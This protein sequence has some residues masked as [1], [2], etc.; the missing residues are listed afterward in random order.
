M[1][2]PIPDYIPGE[3]VDL[4][5][6]KGW[7]NIREMARNTGLPQSTLYGV[8]YNNRNHRNIALWCAWAKALDKSL[9]TLVY[10]YEND[11]DGL[12]GLIDKRFDDSLSEFA[13]TSRTS[14]DTARRLYKGT[15]SSAICHTYIDIASALG[16]SALDLGDLL[17]PTLN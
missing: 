11:L 14:Y 4:L 6:R 12:Q 15:A 3:I 7:E 1:P 10:L 8:F 9:E 13:R 16:I 2:R 5:S 17:I